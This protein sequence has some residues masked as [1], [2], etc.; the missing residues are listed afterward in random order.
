MLRTSRRFPR[1]ERYGLTANCD[2]QRCPLPQ[3]LQ[4][5]TAGSRAENTS[6][7]LSIA[8]GS[9]R[10]VDTHLEFALR[11]RVRDA[12]TTIREFA[13]LARLTRPC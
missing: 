9:L 13:R 1:E 10:E 6:I 4:R 5:E 12:A 7:T 11:L 3:T 8:R 2:A